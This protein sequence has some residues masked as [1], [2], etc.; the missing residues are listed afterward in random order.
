MVAVADICETSCTWTSGWL[1]H[2][3]LVL[4]A[5]FYFSKNSQRE[6]LPLHIQHRRKTIV[7]DPQY[8]LSRINKENIV[9]PITNDENNL[10]QT[11]ESSFFGGLNLD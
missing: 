11:Q 10:N 6:I 9:K 7:H 8:A 2:H 4:T 3:F 1:T 5:P